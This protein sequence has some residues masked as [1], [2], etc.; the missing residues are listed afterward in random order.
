MI[1]RD[2]LIFFVATE[3][4]EPLLHLCIGRLENTTGLNFSRRDPVYLC[5]IYF[6]FR[7]KNGSKYRLYTMHRPPCCSFLQFLVIIVHFVFLNPQFMLHGGYF[8]YVSNYNLTNTQFTCIAS[9]S[10]HCFN[11][12]LYNI[13]P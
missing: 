7:S 5:S 10:L 4:F 11:G 9:L 12:P 13:F 3:N 6:R 8:V 2:F 1:S